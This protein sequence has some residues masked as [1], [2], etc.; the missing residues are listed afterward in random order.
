MIKSKAQRT[1]GKDHRMKHEK[2]FD[3]YP[4]DQLKIISQKGGISSGK[5][6]RAKRIKVNQEKIQQKARREIASEEILALRFTAR[7]MLIEKEMLL[8]EM[9]KGCSVNR[10]K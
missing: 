3:K 2:S 5:S 9:K 4:P 6:R 10:G 7:K 8:E 1:A